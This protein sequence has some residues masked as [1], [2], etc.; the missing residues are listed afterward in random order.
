MTS[1]R[2]VLRDVIH[3]ILTTEIHAKV[4]LELRQ[5]NAWISTPYTLC[6]QFRN[7]NTN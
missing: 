3:E 4:T 2:R 7:G 5:S 1:S 6:G